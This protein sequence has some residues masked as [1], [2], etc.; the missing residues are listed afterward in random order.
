MSRTAST[1]RFGTIA[2]GVVLGMATTAVA[3]SEAVRLERWRL[4]AQDY[5]KRGVWVEA[6]RCYDEVLRKDRLNLA[7]REGYLRCCRRWQLAARHADPLHR[8]LLARL[9]LPQALDAYEQILA[10][11]ALAY[12]DRARTTHAG[13]FHQGVHELR[14]ALDDTGF[15]QEYLAGVKPTAV[16]AF[17]ERLAGWPTRRVA[18]RAEARDQAQLLIR[19]AARDGVALRPMA[20]CAFTLELAAGACA[21]LDEYSGFLSPGHLALLQAASRGKLVSVGAELGV[22]DDRVQVVR[23]HGKSPA[24]EG[25]L[26][27]GDRITRIGGVAVDDLSAEAVAERLRGEPGSLVEVEYV[28]P[29][30]VGPRRTVKLLR[31]AVPAASVE[32]RLMALDDGSPVGYLAIGQFQESTLIEVQEA[33]ATLMGMGGEPIKGLLLDLRGN[34]G[35]LFKSAVAVAE[36]FIADGVVV[37]GQSLLKEYNRPFRA[38]GGGPIQLPTVVLIDAETASAAEVLAAAL[39]DVRTPRFPTRLIGQTTYGKGSIQCIIPMDKPPL[40]NLAGVRLTVARLLSPSQQPIT[41]RG[42]APH[43]PSDREGEALLLEA[44]KHLLDLISPG[45]APRPMDMPGGES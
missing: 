20:A 24:Q 14:L 26:L 27:R 31:R 40:D 9:T 33:L 16:Q 15:R 28:R 4:K 30:E 6:C 13:L 42:I 17:K 3:A 10:T 18:T 25:G 43:V 41:G 35:G 1:L 44:R 12:P 21:A 38:E 5:E 32:A 36:L 39:K 11:V 29:G 8:Q 34:P 45:M 7:A 2:L 22:I 23:I 37:I 19:A